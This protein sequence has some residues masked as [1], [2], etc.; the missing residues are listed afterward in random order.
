MKSPLRW[1]GGKRR[2]AET[3]LAHMP[4]HGAYVETCCGGAA[5]FWAKHRELSQAEILN[6]ADGELINFYAMLHNRG[7]RLAATHPPAVTARP[8]SC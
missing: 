4:P 5:V 8:A 7:R 3:I 2:L 1:P 6:D